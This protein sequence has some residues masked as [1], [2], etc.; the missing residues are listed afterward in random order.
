[1]RDVYW[2][3]YNNTYL[4]AQDGLVAAY[5]SLSDGVDENSQYRRHELDLTM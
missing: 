1:V 2:K 5:P 3:V 4:G